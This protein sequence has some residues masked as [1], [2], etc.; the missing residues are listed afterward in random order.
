M[1]RTES[2]Y[3]IDFP[4]DD[5]FEYMLEKLEKSGNDSVKD[6]KHCDYHVELKKC[7]DIR[8]LNP[9]NSSDTLVSAADIQ[10]GYILQVIPVKKQ[11]DTLEDAIIFYFDTDSKMTTRISFYKD[12]DKANITFKYDR[13]GEVIYYKYDKNAFIVP[14]DIFMVSLSKIRSDRISV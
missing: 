9:I 2:F 7:S 13:C 1:T 5:I 3:I 4:Y 11:V 14:G 8:L 6:D 10:C 12:K